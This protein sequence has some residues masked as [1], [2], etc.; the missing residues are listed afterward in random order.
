MPQMPAY[1]HTN[2]SGMMR[3]GPP[4]AVM[5]GGGEGPYGY[6]S[7]NT[8]PALNRPAH[9]QQ[10]RQNI[11]T[12]PPVHGQGRPLPGSTMPIASAKSRPATTAIVQA[13]NKPAHSMHSESPHAQ[14]QIHTQQRQPP[15]QRNASQPPAQPTLPMS[16]PTVPD[17]APATVPVTET[18]SGAQEEKHEASDMPA[19]E[20]DTVM[21]ETHTSENVS[22]EASVK[23]E[24][25][26]DAD[27]DMAGTVEAETTPSEGVTQSPAGESVLQPGERDDDEE[28]NGMVID[29]AVQ[30]SASVPDGAPVNEQLVAATVGESVVDTVPTR[31]TSTGTHPVEGDTRPQSENAGTATQAAQPVVGN[32][33]V[34]ASRS[35]LSGP[36]SAGVSTDIT[37]SVDKPPQEQLS[38]Q[39]EDA[40]VDG[41][42]LDSHVDK[43]YSTAAE[44]G[45]DNVIQPAVPSQVPDEV[46]A[47]AAQ[48]PT[49]ASMP[50]G[51]DIDS[52]PI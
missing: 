4:G 50:Q 34:E 9:P 17:T 44:A 12:Q 40:E 23:N 19:A 28:S 21:G 27:T 39:A 24:V 51:M 7:T 3:E 38:G 47:P 16:A 20:L 42:V 52:A 33:T 46:P 29:D 22:A 26:A 45:S 14:T 25:P 35:A 48:A 31:A 5:N 30:E 32:G 11:H 18:M 37:A 43:P 41:M 1:Q 10:P 49:T 8:P 2:T 13:Q 6:R 36:Q 15:P